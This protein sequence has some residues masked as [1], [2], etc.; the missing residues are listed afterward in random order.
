MRCIVSQVSTYR[1]I[2]HLMQAAN[3]MYLYLRRDEQN[4]KCNVL[5]ALAHGMGGRLRQIET[6]HFM[7]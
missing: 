7:C 6:T 5:A 1:T 2:V 3:E 4:C